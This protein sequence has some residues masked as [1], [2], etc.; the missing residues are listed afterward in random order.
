MKERLMGK[1]DDGMF[2]EDWETENGELLPA[3]PAL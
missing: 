2:D 3:G 1:L